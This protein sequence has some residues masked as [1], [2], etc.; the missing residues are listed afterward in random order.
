HAHLP[1]DIRTACFR[2]AQEALANAA[3][4]AGA[5][6]VKLQLK[7]AGNDLELTV[8]DN[9]AGFDLERHR[10]PEERKNHV[11]LVTMAERA[12][13]L[14]GS[15]DIDTAPGRGTR[16]RASLPIAANAEVAESAA[17]G[18]ANI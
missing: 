3:R 8:S 15:L 7:L 10:S 5:S 2:I 12:N 1:S 17:V 13:L 11:G 14:G 18:P 16:I 9:G 6:E 4:H